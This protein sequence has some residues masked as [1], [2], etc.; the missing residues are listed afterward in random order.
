MKSQAGLDRNIL[1]EKHNRIEVLEKGTDYVMVLYLLGHF[2][3]RCAFTYSVQ[4]EEGFFLGKN[5]LETLY[6]NPTSLSNLN[7]QI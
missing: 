4:S 7:S 3:F 6:G 2:E 5:S 1:K